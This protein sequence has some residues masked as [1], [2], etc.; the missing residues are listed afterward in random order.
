M[1]SRLALLFAVFIVAGGGVGCR[2]S[3]RAM[4]GISR[5]QLPVQI[6]TGGVNRPFT[7]EDLT[8]AG[9]DPH[10][11]QSSN[12]S[13]AVARPGGARFDGYSD[14]KAKPTIVMVCLSGGGARA[15][16]MAAHTL[17]ELER[18]YNSVSEITGPPFA[19]RIDAWSGVSGG[20]VYASFVAARIK[21]DEGGRND[22]FQTVCDGYRGFL[23]TRQLGG[24]AAFSYLWGYAPVMQITTE[25]DTLHLFAHNLAFLQNRNPFVFPATRA[26]K[27][28]DLPEK[29]RFFFNATC[30][31]TGRPFIFT[32]SIVHRDL[33]G[34]PLERLNGTVN[35][36][37]WWVTN[38]QDNALYPGAVEPFQHASTLEDIGGPPN[39]IPLAYAVMASAAFPGVFEPLTLHHYFFN[40]NATPISVRRRWMPW[41]QFKVTVVD[42]GVY[43][44]SGLITALQL[45]DY[46]R[47]CDGNKRLILLSIDAN[48]HI[49]NYQGPSGASWMP[50]RVDLPF[51]GMIPALETLAS[52][53]ANQQDL[54][55]AIINRRVRA[56]EKTG[57]LEYY[58]IRLKDAV[59][60]KGPG[61]STFKQAQKMQ[62]DA[63][64]VAASQ[65]QRFDLFG[66]I[67]NIP[68][69]FVMKTGEDR[70]LKFVVN[71]LLDRV[72]SG[73]TQSV[74]NAFIQAIRQS[75]NPLAMPQPPR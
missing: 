1:L 74:G 35:P 43:D 9:I 3:E 7:E 63:E 18:R 73:Q 24:V 34:D 47:A 27:L 48:N 2:F 8:Q 57:A 62:G 32:Q 22:T 12:N 59:E 56:L 41:R 38:A 60:M 14:L 65:L 66:I 52:I 61:L 36:V 39:R 42:G 16:R 44:N 45:F 15:A 55:Q 17:A 49:S 21:L 70:H 67:K 54:V 72:P 58:S 69:D 20:S 53:Y 30:R 10:T 5:V 11:L 33:S 64:D 13:P 31:E 6:S 37:F 25:W 26:C 71:L 40:T 29:P 23:G 46:L 50:L 75:P 4:I 19:D 51:R 68:T 28:G